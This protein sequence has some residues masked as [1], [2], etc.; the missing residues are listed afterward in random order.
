MII[1]S[2]PFF[3][4]S[5]SCLY[6]ANVVVRRMLT[7]D[8]SLKAWK[9]PFLLPDVK[10]SVSPKLFWGLGVAQITACAYFG[11]ATG[12]LAIMSASN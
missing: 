10:H 7:N 5:A 2:I 12:R 3:I 9:L 1:V 4:L 8:P 11:Y 6:L